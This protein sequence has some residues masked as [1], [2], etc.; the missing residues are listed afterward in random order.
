MKK[1]R[2]DVFLAK[3]GL[4]DYYIKARKYLH[5]PPP[6]QILC[7]IDPKLEGSSVRGYTYYHYKMDRTPQEIWYIGFQNDPPE[8]TTLLHELIHV[9]GGCEI[10]AH[11]YVGILRYAIENDLPP[12]PLLMLPD[13]KIE[14]IE[15]ALAKLGINSIDEY[16]DI[17][18]IIPPTHELQIT[19]NG[20]KI[21]RREGA[22]ERMLVE[23]F[24]IELSSALDWPEYNPLEVKIIEVLAETLR[25]KFQK[26]S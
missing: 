1:E 17:K 16:Y 12:F 10:T 14:E 6:D 4:L 18:G 3:R 20:L 8:I 22:D 19:Q 9:A 13:L 26:T 23:V 25:K 7:F 21:A 2:I 24:L 15:K 5:L 11:N